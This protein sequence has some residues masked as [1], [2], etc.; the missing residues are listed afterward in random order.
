MCR[1]K[2]AHHDW[3]PGG[4]G[5]CSKALS[6][7]STVKNRVFGFG[8]DQGTENENV[9]IERQNKTES[10]IEIKV[11][12][13]FCLTVVNL[14]IVKMCVFVFFAKIINQ[15]YYDILISIMII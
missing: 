13:N 7:F 4:T 8:S 9:K 11:I 14:Y 3:H 15:W 2:Q 6:L 12:I 5:G 1:H 10:K